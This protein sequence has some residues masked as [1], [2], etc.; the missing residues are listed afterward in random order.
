M[1]RSASGDKSREGQLHNK[2]K[3]TGATVVKNGK[4]RRHIDGG[5]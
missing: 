5:R 3:A 4:L 2:F 1:T